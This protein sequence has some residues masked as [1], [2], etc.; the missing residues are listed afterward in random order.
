LWALKNGI[1]VE[2]KNKNLLRGVQTIYKKLGS[3]QM[4]K[5]EAIPLLEKALK[6]QKQKRND[7]QRLEDTFAAAEVLLQKHQTIE[8]A[9]QACR[10]LSNYKSTVT[11]YTGH[12]AKGLEFDRVVFLDEKLCT[13]RDQDS[14]IRYVIVTRARK[15]LHYVNTEE[16]F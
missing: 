7:H 9:S 16:L 6:K 8:K 13:D 2:L 4:H 15:D 3:P 12:R 11:L 14:N 1:V 5:D 10:A